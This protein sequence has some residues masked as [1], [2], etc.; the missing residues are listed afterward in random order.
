MSLL[1]WHKTY[2]VLDNQL[3]YNFCW[4]EIYLEFLSKYIPTHVSRAGITTQG[5]GH[6][7]KDW[8]K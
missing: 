4:L 5:E 6:G 8:G 7:N 3:L 1:L 2:I